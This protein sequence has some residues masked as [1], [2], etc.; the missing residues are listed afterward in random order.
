[1]HYTL[2][3]CTKWGNEHLPLLEHQL[4][5]FFFIQNLIRGSI[6]MRVVSCK[7]VKVHSSSI[8]P[9]RHMLIG[10]VKVNTNKE[11][12]SHSHFYSISLTTPACHHNPK[13]RHFNQSEFC[14]HTAKPIRN[15]VSSRTPNVFTHPYPT[16]PDQLLST[17]GAA[18]Y[19]PV[20]RL[21]D[22]Y[23][24]PSQWEAKSPM[25]KYSP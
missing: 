3:I 13:R 10:A 14:Y 8:A 12:C 20:S 25:F 19:I 22:I 24:F 4:A 15:Q 11:P 18:D 6:L 17:F 16:P 21:T 7:A 1:M 2:Y 5:S 23:S 9:K